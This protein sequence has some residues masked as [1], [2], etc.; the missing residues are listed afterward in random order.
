MFTGNIEVHK[1]SDNVVYNLDV[2]FEYFPPLGKGG[3]GVMKGSVSRRRNV[4]AV[5]LL[6]DYKPLV[7]MFKHC[8]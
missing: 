8:L 2:A 3:N 1:K 5:D 6:I 4:F 7:N